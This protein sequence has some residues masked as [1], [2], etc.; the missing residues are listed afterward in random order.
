[1][2]FSKQPS[3]QD[4][5]TLC[6]EYAKK[7]KQK[8]PTNEV[9]SDLKVPLKQLQNHKSLRVH[10][11]YDEVINDHVSSLATKVNECLILCDYHGFGLG[12]RKRSYD[13]VC[14][15]LSKMGHMCKEEGKLSV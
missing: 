1:M 12:Q 5:G 4:L 2:F 11:K 8:L 13:K 3:L 14:E 15:F 6:I 9:F 7:H 10:Y